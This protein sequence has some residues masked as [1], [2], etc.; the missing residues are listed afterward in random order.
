MIARAKRPPRL[1]GAG[2]AFR[3][4]IDRG[5]VLAFCHLAFILWGGCSTPRGSSC[6]PGVPCSVQSWD[7]AAGDFHRLSV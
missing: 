2:K 6:P 7:H 3:A 4:V 5:Y 1:C